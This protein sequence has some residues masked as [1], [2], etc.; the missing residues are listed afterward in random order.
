M[1]YLILFSLIANLGCVSLNDVYNKKPGHRREIKEF[2]DSVHKDYGIA[3]SK[4]SIGDCIVKAS[5]VERANRY[6]MF[7]WYSQIAS[8]L[9]MLV[10]YPI[11]V[12]SSR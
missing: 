10:L 7:W 2:C 5:L 3:Q 4:I 12:I 8:S 1:R 11:I 9:V 6:E